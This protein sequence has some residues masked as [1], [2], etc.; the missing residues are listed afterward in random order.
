MSVSYSFTPAELTVPIFIGIVSGLSLVFLLTLAYLL[1]GFE[2]NR[3]KQ[4]QL[5]A[6]GASLP[7]L[8]IFLTTLVIEAA[9]FFSVP[10]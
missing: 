10:F 2:T 7:I 4:H 5:L 8:L 6:L 9:K 1:G 3:A